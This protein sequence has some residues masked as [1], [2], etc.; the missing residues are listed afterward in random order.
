MKDDRFVE[1]ILEWAIII[2]AALSASA[3]F[4]GVYCAWT[5]GQC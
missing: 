1:S 3:I 5:W 4:I 2:I